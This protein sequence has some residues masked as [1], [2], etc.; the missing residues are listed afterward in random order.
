MY[1]LIIDGISRAYVFYLW[2]HLLEH[3]LLQ[4]RSAM[5]WF[6]WHINCFLSV[7]F[8][9]VAVL[10]L[11]VPWAH[12]VSPP[13]T[14]P[15]MRVGLWWFWQMGWWTNKM[16]LRS[17]RWTFSFHLISFITHVNSCRVCDTTLVSLIQPSPS[18]SSLSSIRSSSS[19]MLN[20]APSSARGKITVLHKI[21]KLQDALVT[22]SGPQ[23]ILPFFLFTVS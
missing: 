12:F 20:S 18:S 8:V 6:Q 13:H 10:T 11:S 1:L 23:L 14:P 15:L 2:R 5:F 17:C 7:F 21:H 16:I 19:Q 4:F 22:C 9:L 3:L